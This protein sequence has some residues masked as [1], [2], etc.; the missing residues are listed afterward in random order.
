MKKTYIGSSELVKTHWNLMGR[1]SWAER[2]PEIWPEKDL[3]DFSSASRSRSRIFL[4][5][6]KSRQTF[7]MSWQKPLRMSGEVVH[8]LLQLLL[9]CIWHCVSLFKELSPWKTVPV[10]WQGHSPLIERDISASWTQQ[11][12]QLQE[13]RQDLV[14]KAGQEAGWRFCWWQHVTGLVWASPF[15]EH[16]LCS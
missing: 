3:P 1:L 12:L 7:V 15:C 9:Y 13:N 2:R 14:S 5:L 4:V 8:V 11:K 6:K 10:L 16:P